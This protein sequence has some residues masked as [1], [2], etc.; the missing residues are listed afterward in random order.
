MYDKEQNRRVANGLF[1]ALQ[2]FMLLF[3][4]AFI[5]TLYMALQI[6]IN[7]HHISKVIMIAPLA[8]TLLYPYTLYTSRKLFHKGNPSMAMGM[9]M[10]WSILIIA[11]LYAVVAQFV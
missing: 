10:G 2:L 11:L 5:Y 1:T 7:E 8:A 9:M 4:Y 6:A 3:T